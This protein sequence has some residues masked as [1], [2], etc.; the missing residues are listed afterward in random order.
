MSVILKQVGYIFFPSGIVADFFFPS[1]SDECV[2][3]LLLSAV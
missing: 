3:I 2:I 1:S